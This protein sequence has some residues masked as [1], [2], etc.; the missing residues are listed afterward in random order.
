MV[1]SRP[2]VACRVDAQTAA[3]PPGTVHLPRVMQA[4]V[5]CLVA[6]LPGVNPRRTPA[7]DGF[8]PG[9]TPGNCTVLDGKQHPS[10]SA[11]SGCHAAQS[12]KVCATQSVY[13]CLVI[14]ARSHVGAMS[15]VRIHTAV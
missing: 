13:S 7:N 12:G 11:S 15:Q 10:K 5:Q 1:P 2:A 8:G 4:V 9:M 14:A 3:L 6:R